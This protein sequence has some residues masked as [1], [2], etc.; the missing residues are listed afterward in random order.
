MP[1][2][3]VGVEPDYHRSHDS[4]ANVCS[5]LFSLKIF[6]KMC[7]LGEKPMFILADFRKNNLSGVKM[8]TWIYRKY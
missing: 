5:I 3:T 7:F 2:Q 8:V 6:I 1:S 4:S